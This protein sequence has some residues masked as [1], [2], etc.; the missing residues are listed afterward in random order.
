MLN[1]QTVQLLSR[2]WLFWDPMDCSLPDASVH[3][4]QG[5][6]LECVTIPFSRGPYWPLGLNSNLLSPALAVGFF[7]WA[8]W[9]ATSDTNCYCRQILH[10]SEH[11][12]NPKLT[13][14]M[15]LFRRRQWQPTPVLSPGKSHGW[16]SL[17]GC[18]LCSLPRQDWSDLAAAAC[19]CLTLYQSVWSLSES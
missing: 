8:T 1:S 4:F 5:R 12:G 15:H 2:V 10:P 18:R 9:E 7:T 11:Q 14:F 19:T 3:I 13:P 6:L 16:G 17:V